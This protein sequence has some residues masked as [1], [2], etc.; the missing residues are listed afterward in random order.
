MKPLLIIL[1]IVGSLICTDALADDPFGIATVPAPEGGLSTIWFGLQQAIEADELT[2]KACRADRACG[3]PAALRLIAIVDEAKRSKGRAM[4]GHINRS[5]NLAVVGTR[6]DVPWRSPLAALVAPGDCKSYAIA[7]YAALADAGIAPVDRRL[8]MV[9]DNVRPRGT[10][11]VVVVRE[12]ARWLILDNRTMTLVESTEV[13]SYQPL[14][15]F[16]ATGV[17]DFP[18]LAAGWRSALGFPRPKMQKAPISRG[19]F[20]R[21]ERI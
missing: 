5:I 4:L 11:M 19:F 2:I 1:G 17:R 6:A 10:H 14:R 18:A 7:K 15:E 3:S 20:G 21:S 9:W 13:P 8:V 16:D 12:G